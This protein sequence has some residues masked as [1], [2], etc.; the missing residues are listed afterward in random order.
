MMSGGVEDL[1]V[2]VPGYQGPHGPLKDRGGQFLAA[3]E[4]VALRQIPNGLVAAHGCNGYRGVHNGHKHRLRGYPMRKHR[5]RCK[6]PPGQ[7]RAFPWGLCP[8]QRIEINMTAGGSHTATKWPQSGRMRGG[9]GYQCSTGQSLPLEGK[10]LLCSV[11]PYVDFCNSNAVTERAGHAPPL[12]YLARGRY[13]L[14][15]SPYRTASVSF[16][17]S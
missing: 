2:A 17:P 6:S 7:R 1:P 14:I 12:Q 11:S 3:Q 5:R 13:P 16:S 4:G 10:A 9:R 15:R 8:A